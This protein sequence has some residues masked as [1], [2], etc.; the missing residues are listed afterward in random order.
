MPR[1]RKFFHDALTMT[2]TGASV[3]LMSEQ[4]KRRHVTGVEAD[5]WLSS[6]SFVQKPTREMIVS[7]K[8]GTGNNHGSA[9]MELYSIPLH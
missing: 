7:V 4:I 3:S 6:L 1:F 2:G 8:V 5:M 9:N